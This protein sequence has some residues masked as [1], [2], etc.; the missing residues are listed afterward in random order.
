MRCSQLTLNSMLT[1]SATSMLKMSRAITQTAKILSEISVWM[2]SSWLLLSLDIAEVLPAARGCQKIQPH[3]LPKR[4]LYLG[5]E[6][7]LFPS[8][9]TAAAANAPQLAV[10]MAVG[11]AVGSASVLEDVMHTHTSQQGQLT[12]APLLSTSR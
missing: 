8:A 9:H 7:P 3:L 4:N 11:S 1:T 10:L 2:T 12:A 6:Q 5:D